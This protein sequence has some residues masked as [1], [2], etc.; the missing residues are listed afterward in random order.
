MSVAAGDVAT[1][2]ET[3]QTPHAFSLDNVQILPIGQPAAWLGVEQDGDAVS[4]TPHA[5]MPKRCTIH[6]AAQRGAN[7]WIIPDF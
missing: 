1:T 5:P 7:S 2:I 4:I 3:K 6:P